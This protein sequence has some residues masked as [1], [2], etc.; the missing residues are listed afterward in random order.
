MNSYRFPA[1]PFDG[2][3]PAF[4]GLAG[5]CWTSTFR[6]INAFLDASG[7]SC[8]PDDPPQPARTATKRF[9]VANGA[10]RRR[11]R[12]G[13]SPCTACS[14]GLGFNCLNRSMPVAAIG[15][16]WRLRPSERLFTTPVSALT[17]IEAPLTD[18]PNRPADQRSQP[19]Q[20]GDERTN[21]TRNAHPAG[22]DSECLLQSVNQDTPVPRRAMSPI[23]AGRS[24]DF[25]AGVLSLLI[26]RTDSRSDQQW[27]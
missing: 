6:W 15:R 10:T 17:V 22:R 25:R 14:P 26:G 18:E 5:R 12:V 3:L 7:I 23:D 27:Q 20:F 16:H 13:F 4:D 19:R 24:S 21:E 1:R 2:S 11:V 8:T 9:K